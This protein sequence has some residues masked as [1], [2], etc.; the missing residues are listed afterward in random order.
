M[1]QAEASKPLSKKILLS[2]LFGLIT[3]LFGGLVVMYYLGMYSEIEIHRDVAPPYRMAYVLHTG[4]Y[5]NF[6][7]DIEKV[8]VQLEKQRI[9]PGFPF[10]LFLDDAGRVPEEKRRVKVGYFVDREAY[11]RPPLEEETLPQREV[12]IARFKGGRKLGSYKVYKAM[13]EWAKDHGYN[14]KLPA[15]EIYRS[16]G[17]T[18]YQLGIVKKQGSQ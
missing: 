6:E 5:A 11:I 15:L 2:I 12:I 9:K 4:S 17:E 18:E 10:A 13:K 14:L 3:A 8:R 1:N 16:E 7:E